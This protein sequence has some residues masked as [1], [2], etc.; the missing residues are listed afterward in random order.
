MHSFNFRYSGDDEYII[1]VSWKQ[2][3][4]KDNHYVA[5]YMFNLFRVNKIM[6]H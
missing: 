1:S 3:D 2:S 6:I 5:C 4:E